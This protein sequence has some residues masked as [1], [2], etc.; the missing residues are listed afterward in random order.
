MK[1]HKDNLLVDGKLL[2]SKLQIKEVTSH[3]RSGEIFMVVLANRKNY[4]PRDGEDKNF[5]DFKHIKPF[6]IEQ[7]RVKAK[8]PKRCDDSDKNIV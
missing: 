8:M 2:I 7:V 6:V 4:N 1:G 3:F 5:I